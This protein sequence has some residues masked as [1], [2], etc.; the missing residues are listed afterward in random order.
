MRK[1][2][3]QMS[4]NTAALPSDLRR[5]NRMQVL[6]VFK[7]GGEFTINQ[8]AAQVGLSRQTVMK[9]VQFFVEQ[10]IVAAVEK[11]GSDDPQAIAK[12]YC[13]VEVKGMAGDIKIS[14]ETHNPVGKSGCVERI[15]GKNKTYVFETYIAAE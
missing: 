5:S 13:E 14:P 9:A 15:D 2:L 12:A 10:G 4:G 8:I 11:A 3:D 1:V 7:W 6:E